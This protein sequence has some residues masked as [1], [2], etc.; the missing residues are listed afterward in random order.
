MSA[1]IV[2]LYGP[3]LS[4]Y[5]TQ[6][7]PLARRDASVRPSNTSLR[8]YAATLK[9]LHV[10]ND[11]LQSRA[12]K[13]SSNTARLELD[14]MKLQLHVKAFHEELLVTWQADILTRLVEVV[15]ERSGWRLPGGIT[16][17]S[18]ECMD[19]TKVSLMYRTAARKI[20]KETLE[21]KFGLSVRYYLA[22][23][24][25]DEVAY[26]RSTNSFRSECTF[27]RWLM[28]QKEKNSR[29]GLFKFWGKLFPLCYGRTVKEIS[30]VL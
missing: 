29:M 10:S 28:S 3:G 13:L 18:H 21:S 14:V 4:F 11:R 5:L 24:K 30:E 19:Q 9:A 25:Y 7:K 6:G 8:A 17:H 12:K 26:F 1:D 27:A 16:A 15:Y 22:L 23:Q 2:Q 20:K